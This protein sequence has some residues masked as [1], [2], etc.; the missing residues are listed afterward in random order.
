VVRTIMTGLQTLEL[1]LRHILRNWS[2]PTWIRF[3]RFRVGRNPNAPRGFFSPL[4]LPQQKN[5]PRQEGME[6]GKDRRSCHWLSAFMPLARHAPPTTNRRRFNG[7]FPRSSNP[8]KNN[9][10]TK[11]D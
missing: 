4:F 9:L 11:L 1:A 7:G 5:G 6:V 10:G 8:E 3:L 2:R